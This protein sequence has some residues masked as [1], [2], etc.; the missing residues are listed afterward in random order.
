MFFVVHHYDN[1]FLGM[2]DG[3][4]TVVIKYKKVPSRFGPVDGTYSI[5]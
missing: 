3:Q 5:F 2:T 4:M 1:G